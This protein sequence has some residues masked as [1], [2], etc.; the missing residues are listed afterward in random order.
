ML[1]KESFSAQKSDIMSQLKSD[2]DNFSDNLS[3][4]G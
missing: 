2:M 4:L 3:R 1:K